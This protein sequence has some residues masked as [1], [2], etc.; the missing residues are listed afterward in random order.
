MEK[1]IDR[2]VLDRY[3]EGSYTSADY[4]QVKA[5]F[6]EEALAVQRDGLIRETW[7]EF[8]EKRPGKDLSFILQ[9]IQSRIYRE[10]KSQTKTLWHFY[11]QIAA[12]LLLPI[13][14]FM[15]YLLINRSTQEIT[16]AWAEIHS[17]LGARTQFT[18]PD[19]TTGW[20]NS[21]S[22]IQYPVDFTS[23][24]VKMSGEAFFHVVHQDNKKFIVQ[25]PALDITV[26]GTRF[27]VAAYAED[28]FVEVALEE[29]R[30]RLDSKNGKL[31]ESLSPDQ[32][33]I[34][35][36]AQGKG[37]KSQVDADIYSLWKEGKLVFRD[38]PLSVVLKK[39]ER[40]YNVRFDIKDTQLKDHIYKA[41]FQDETLEEALRVL[42]WSAPIDYE[43]QDRK[44]N[45]D[46]TYSEKTI[47]VRKRIK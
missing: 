21:G 31:S 37:S 14:L 4:Q 15:A 10:E 43:I 36:P 42:A 32:R 35:Y 46:G 6:E 26:L 3:L 5:L 23:R 38:D 45:E 11:R 34:F 22:S 19:G 40:W 25:T 18:L 12:V 27:N 39:M 33:F 30:V 8:E 2:D 1:K 20:L 28:P 24:K 13:T 17:P 9:K 7:V 44:L 16:T 41:T 29:G 47:I